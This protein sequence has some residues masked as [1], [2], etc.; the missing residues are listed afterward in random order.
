MG[1]GLKYEAMTIPA[2]QAQLIEQLRWT[3]E[4][5]ASCF[6]VPLHKIG[7]A[8]NVKFSNM[9]EM[10]QDYYSQTLQGLIESIE[11]LLDEGLGLTGGPQTLGVELD[12]EGLLRMD[13]VQRAQRNEINV[14]AGIWSPNEARATD[15]MPPVAGG[16]QPFKQMQDIPLAAL[17]NQPTKGLAADADVQARMARLL[18]VVEK[19]VYSFRARAT[20]TEVRTAPAISQRNGRYL[21]RSMHD[22]GGAE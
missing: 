12:L 4:A 5:V 11:L 21:T 2:Q 7:A 18:D 17:A 16:E 20:S 14:K 6:H 15:N 8:T 22:E 19:A 9:A 1:D 3:V 10:N 13:P